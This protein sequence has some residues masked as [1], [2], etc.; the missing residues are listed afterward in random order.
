MD[1]HAAAE[2]STSVVEDR[3]AY[4]RSQYGELLDL[5]QVAE[6]FKY[7]SVQ[8]VR[9]AYRQGSLPVPLHRFP[10]K[11]GYYAKAR[12]VANSIDVMVVAVASA[13]ETE[14]SCR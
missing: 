11:T 3:L 8:A 5:P 6:F 2:I 12:D 14:L 13:H 1:S 7:S 10:R 9:R 4:I